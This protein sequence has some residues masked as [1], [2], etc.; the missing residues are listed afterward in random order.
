MK[1]KVW[2]NL[3]LLIHAKEKKMFNNLL[4]EPKLN[5][6]MF[7][8]IMTKNEKIAMINYFNDFANLGLKIAVT[9]PLILES[10]HYST[11]CPK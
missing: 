7:Q 8:I 1:V 6:A 4:R 10:Y 11:D 5:P 9:D 3:S 2:T